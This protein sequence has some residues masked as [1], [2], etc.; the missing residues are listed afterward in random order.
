[1]LL[2]TI[3]LPARVDDTELHRRKII[4]D[5]MPG[6]MA[7]TPRATQ[8]NGRLENGLSWSIGRPLR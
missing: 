6:S 5:A 7:S 3:T 1:M 4:I 8:L 2:G